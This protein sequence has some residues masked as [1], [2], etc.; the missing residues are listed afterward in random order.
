MFTKSKRTL[1]LFAAATAACLFCFA[2]ALADH[3]GKPHGKPGGGGGEAKLLLAWSIFCLA[4]S[5]SSWMPMA[6]IPKPCP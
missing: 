5:H 1:T 6:T 2:L 3:K 4:A